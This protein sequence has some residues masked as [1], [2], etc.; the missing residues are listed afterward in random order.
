LA[1]IVHDVV[2]ELELE[3][4]GAVELALD[5]DA[6]AP[7]SADR[8]RT[9]VE[10]L[11]RNAAE[12]HAPGAPTWICA[13]VTADARGVVLTIDDAGLGLSAEALARCTCPMRPRPQIANR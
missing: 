9:V 4:R 8:A 1:P 13:Q 12:A 3:S 6:R 11:L 10:N 5:E 2:R 7:V